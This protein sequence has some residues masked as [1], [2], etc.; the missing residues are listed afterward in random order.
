MAIKP[1][2]KIKVNL[3]EINLLPQ[4]FTECK[5]NAFYIKTARNPDNY[6]EVFLAL[7]VQSIEAQLIGLA[8]GYIQDN[9]KRQFTLKL[10]KIEVFT[11]SILFKRVLV[12]EYLTSFEMEVLKGIEH[13]NIE[14]ELSKFLNG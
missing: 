11:L 4:Y 2:K 1:Y 5:R 9:Q 6:L 13:P 8:C 10:S 3:S 14:A 12:H 7:A